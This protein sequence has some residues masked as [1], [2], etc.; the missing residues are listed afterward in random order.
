MVIT[1]YQ[2]CSIEHQKP[3]SPLYG[4]KWRRIILDEAHQIRNHKTRSSVAVG[5]LLGKSRWALTGTPVHNRELDMY[6]LLKFLR[7]NPF[8][9][10]AVSSM[11]ISYYFIVFNMIC[12]SR[13]GSVGY[14]KHKQAARTEYTL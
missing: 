5:G 11:L 14:P 6:A 12:Y 10:L 3:S 13:Y 2:I 8:D 7:C 9:D 1:T 4:V